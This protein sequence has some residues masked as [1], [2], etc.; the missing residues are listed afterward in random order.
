M[1]SSVRL[2]C[3]PSARVARSCSTSASRARLASKRTRS[4][5][6]CRPRSA[7]ASAYFSN[8]GPL[9]PRFLAQPRSLGLDGCQPAA[10]VAADVVL[11]GGE[12]E[13]QL[14]DLGGQLA[15]VLL[16]P[17]SGAVQFRLVL[18]AELQFLVR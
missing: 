8:R 3:S 17:G 7:A 1:V 2:S 9:L 11:D 18:E 14:G 10:A 4:S 16:Q 15:G 5:G 12:V 6:A 13:A